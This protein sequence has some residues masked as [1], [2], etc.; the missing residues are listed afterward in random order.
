MK[1]NIFAKSQDGITPLHDAVLANQLE[2]ARLLVD[3]GG[4]Q[5]LQSKTHQGLTPLDYA[6]SKEMEQMLLA[7]ENQMPEFQE[8]NTIMQHHRSSMVKLCVSECVKYVTLVQN[9]IT[10][11]YHLY[12]IDQM[13]FLLQD[14]GASNKSQEHLVQSVITQ[15]MGFEPSFEDLLVQSD[16]LIVAQQLCK[17]LNKFEEHLCSVV[18]AQDMVLETLLWPF[19]LLLPVQKKSGAA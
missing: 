6:T 1:V 17:Y 9:L 4:A 7:A 5:L 14:T 15:C 19:R 12:K 8:I 18:E 11:Y 16:D 10:S 3:Y 13:V 2:I